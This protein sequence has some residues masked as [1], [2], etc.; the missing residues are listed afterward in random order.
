MKNKLFTDEECEWLKSFFDLELSV[1]GDLSKEIKKV[2]D[3][4]VE[5]NYRKGNH[6]NKI[7]NIN[8][9]KLIKFLIDKFSFLGLKSIG[10]V[11][12]VR[13]G[14]GDY[15]GPHTDF[16]RY[17]NDACLKTIIIILSDEDEYGGGDLYVGDTPQSKE[18]GSYVMINSS[19][20]HEVR[21]I[22]W[23]V[24][25]SMVIFL[26]EDDITIEKSIL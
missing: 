20:I 2:G 16:G 4:E 21:V 23:G 8:D 22:E 25:F 3:H 14:E 18:K 5:V 26:W 9:E 15:M 6:K 24:R 1:G 10:G 7:T 19:Q 17:G 12:V 13:Y 11:R